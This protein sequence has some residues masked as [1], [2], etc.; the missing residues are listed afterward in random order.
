MGINS[1]QVPA[2]GPSRGALGTQAQPEGR[3]EYSQLGKLRQR[4]DGVPKVPPRLWS[5]SLWSLQGTLCWLSWLSGGQSPWP[6]PSLLPQP[7][8]LH[9]HHSYPHLPRALALTW[10]LDC[11]LELPTASALG[12]HLEVS[13]LFHAHTLGLQAPPRGSASIRVTGWGGRG[14]GRL[15]VLRGPGRSL[16][17]SPLIPHLTVYTPPDTLT[18]PL[19]HASFLRAPRYPQHN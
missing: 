18:S 12:E 9:P 6:H 19:P 17:P 8:H 13:H 10:P 7:H 15:R 2:P 3:A 16:S 5:V 4:G 11:D 1:G 14:E